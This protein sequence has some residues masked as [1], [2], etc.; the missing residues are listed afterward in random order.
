MAKTAVSKDV[1]VQSIEP[2][3]AHQSE[4]IA[5]FSKTP[6]GF[7]NSDPGTGKTRV[8]IE[9]YRRR[10]KAVRG[11]WLIFCPKTLMSAAWLEDIEKYAPELTVSLAT[12]AQ[13]EEALIMKT[14]VVIINVDGVK[15]FSDKKNKSKLKLLFAFDHLTID[16]YTVYKHGTSQRSKAMRAI[17]KYFKHRYALSGTPNPNTV[18]ELWHPTLILDGGARLGTAYS[19]MR[20]TVQTP[21][22]IGPKPEHVRWD[23]KPGANQAIT[24]LLSDITIRHDFDVVMK[25]VPKNHRDVKS[26]TLS[27]KCQTY[28][29]KMENEAY[30]AMDN[31]TT[32]NAVH[33]AALRTKLLQIASGAV[34]DGGENGSYQVL[35]LRRYELI[36]ELIEECK[37]SV[38]FFNWKHQRDILC[39]T[40]TAAHISFALIDGS[41]S[42]NERLRIVA[43]YQKGMYQTVLLHP[44]TGAHG[45]TLTKGTRTIISSPFYEADLL[46]QAIKRIHRGG[47]TQ[48]TDTLLVQAKNTVEDLVYARLNEKS[49]RM[50]DLLAQMRDRRT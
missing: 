9:I 7:D 8:Q 2:L 50:F 37:H 26:F 42:D 1:A 3:W 13:R 39:K 36:Q 49:E 41:V 4:S 16:E 31:G 15:W 11:R 10:N 46:A 27:T 19:K 18:M 17:S 6:I 14:D 38:V 45:L 47:Q 30:F 28:Y 44:K 29:R 34:Y 25:H 24:E 5:F 40:L 33:A 22:Q 21:T 12:A 43:D 23:D 48:L 32:V 35:D 20:Y